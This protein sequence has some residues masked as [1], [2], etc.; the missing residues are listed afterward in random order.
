MRTPIACAAA[1]P[2][3]APRG[4]TR[5]AA[6]LIRHPV[7]GFAISDVGHADVGFAQAPRGLGM[8]HP[9][10]GFAI[11]D[12]GHADVGVAQAP[13]GLGIRHPVDGFAIFHFGDADVG[14][15]QAPRSGAA[16][17]RDPL[18]SSGSRITSRER[19]GCRPG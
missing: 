4:R 7:D 8:R 6:S 14:F 19:A 3:H 18:R 16:Q 15:A 1:P 5:R 13:R 9:V 10:D 11:S 17:A 2:D 12:V